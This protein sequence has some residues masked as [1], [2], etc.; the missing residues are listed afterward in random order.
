MALTYDIFCKLY[1]IGI[2]IA[3][4]FNPKAKLWIKGRKGIF[5]QLEKKFENAQNPLLWMHCA[6]L[7]EFE[8]GRPVLE[9]FRKEYP[10]YKILLT[11]FSPS[12][13]EIRKDYKGA[14]YIFYLPNDSEENA[15]RFVEITKP[16]LAIFVKYEFWH[17][18]LQTLKL[19]QIPLLLISAVFRPDQLFF[20]KHGEFF[21]K[22]LE[23]FR[24]FFVQNQDSLQLLNSIGITQATVSG[25]T[26]F[27]RVWEVRQLWQP[28]TIIENFCQDAPIL[29][30]GSTWQEDEECLSI[31]IKKNPSVKSI[32]VPHDISEKRIEDCLQTFPDA[33]RYSDYKENSQNHNRVLII[34]N[35]GMLNRLY[36]YATI[37]YIGGGWGNKGIHNILEAAVYGKP[38]FYGPHFS[39]NYEAQDLIDA[40]GAFSSENPQELSEK[41]DHIL[42]NENALTK[43]SQAALDFVKSRIGATEIIMQYISL[44]NIHS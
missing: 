26:R 41:M 28:I 38:V 15:R 37:T 32:I 3:S 30:A 40:G 25:D 36:Q 33:I 27:D 29:V 44:L 34:D 23:C 21:K 24:Y 5:Q 13:Y 39:K 19:H 42:Q 6:S 7:G 35:I 12:G 43:S 18:Y 11:F 16:T 9:S 2:R 1:P 4:L 8:M 10:N 22:D 14:D 20:K 31:F 17:Y